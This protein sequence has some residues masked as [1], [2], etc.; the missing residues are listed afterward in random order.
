M[1]EIENAHEIHIDSPRMRGCH[2]Q[3]SRV[4]RGGIR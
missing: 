3:A 2:L 4:A 1:P